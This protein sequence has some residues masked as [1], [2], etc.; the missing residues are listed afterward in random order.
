MAL[1]PDLRE[2]LGRVGKHWL[3]LVAGGFVAALGL[4]SNATNHPAPAWAWVAVVFTF[5]SV[6]QYRA[7]Q[8]LRADLL[9]ARDV[10][11]AHDERLQPK[12]SL[13][14]GSYTRPYVI[15]LDL[16]PV[17]SVDV[18]ERRFRVGVCN[19]STQVIAGVRVLLI[20]CEPG[21][22]SVFPMHAMGGDPASVPP[23]K[24]EPTVFVDELA[25]R[26]AKK[27]DKR[28]SGKSSIVVLCYALG[29]AVTNEV[30]NIHHVLKL[31][32][33][34]GGTYRDHEYRFEPDDKGVVQFSEV[35]P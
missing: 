2:Y 33:E 30:P 20:S 35:R 25:Q 23:T 34:G 27:D 4:I 24:D 13:R 12:L 31:R 17:N 14:F 5:V 19:H 32:V 6:A 22:P 11:N 21:G 18:I 26:T 3:T 9:K 7:Y 16:E 28:W 1:P 10:I 29:T 15:E 8:D